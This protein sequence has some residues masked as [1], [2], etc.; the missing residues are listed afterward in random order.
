MDIILPENIKL[1]AITDFMQSSN[2]K[3]H[4]NGKV[5]IPIVNDVNTIIGY[6]ETNPLYS[7]N[8]TEQYATQHQN[9]E[10]KYPIEDYENSANTNS[11]IVKYTSTI[12]S[13]TDI[14]NHKKIKVGDR[15]KISDYM[16]IVINDSNANTI[17][18][19]EQYH[20]SCLYGDMYGAI[21]D[22]EY[23]FKLNIDRNFRKYINVAIPTE[24]TLQYDYFFK[25]RE[26]MSNRS[27]FIFKD[28]SG[29]SKRWWILHDS[30]DYVSFIDTEGY[31]G[32]SPKNF[33]TNLLTYEFAL[34]P[35]IKI[36]KL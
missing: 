16:F 18:I 20:S 1:E 32:F 35:V 24:K 28:A 11:N 30:N 9:E 3:I 22:F 19:L 23:K 8:T 2:V 36:N 34:R 5:F 4:M 6:V 15:I 27:R 31:H 14:I 33:A 26:D 17:A 25:Y 29:V 12:H 10:F 7:G 21:N 13:F